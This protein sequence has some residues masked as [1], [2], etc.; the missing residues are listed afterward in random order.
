MAEGGGLAAVEMSARGRIG[1][2]YDFLHTQK[3]V[4]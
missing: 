1:K 2:T 3:R 4:T